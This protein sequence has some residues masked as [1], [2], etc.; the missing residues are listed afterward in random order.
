MLTDAKLITITEN[1][2]IAILEDPP[3]IKAAQG[4]TADIETNLNAYLKV[5]YSQGI[6]DLDDAVVAAVL[7]S[8]FHTMD[9]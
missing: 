4:Y 8:E 6:K 3:S 1:L 5:L 2:G 7:L 9:A